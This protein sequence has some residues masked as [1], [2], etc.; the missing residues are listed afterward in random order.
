MNKELALITLQKE[1]EKKKKRNENAKKMRDRRGDELKEKN[2]EYARIH[3]E[4]RKKELEEAKDILKKEEMLKKPEKPEKPEKP[5]ELPIKRDIVKIE[6]DRGEFISKVERTG[7]KGVCEKTAVDYINK[8]SVVHKIVSETELDKDLLKTVLIGK[9]TK[10]DEKKLKANMEYLDN[11]EVLIKTI[12]DRYSNLQSRKA[13]LSSYMTLITYLSNIKKGAYEIIRQKFEEANNEIYGI[14][15]DNQR[16]KNEEM[17]DIFDEEDIARRAD[18]LNMEDKIIYAYYTLQPPRRCEDVYM[19][20]VIKSSE[21]NLD[22]DK[23]YIVIDD[24]NSPIEVIYNKYKTNKIYGRQ[25]IKIS[26]EILKSVI[27]EYIYKND[28]KDGERLYRRFSTANTFGDAIK[29]VF[30]KV[31]GKKIT[32]NN[33]RHSYITWEMRELRSVNYLSNLAMMMGHSMGE[34]QL[35]RRI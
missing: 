25:T 17:I 30:S 10:E 19:L 3:R 18:D 26:N 23:N 24:D 34:Q 21:D 22:N 8:I 35:Y 32:L 13:H 4:K 27:R 29:R 28:I 15:G 2:K 31:Y 6:K 7:I 33:I 14:R 9:G 5:K 20:T 16:A 11:I 12:E 1:L